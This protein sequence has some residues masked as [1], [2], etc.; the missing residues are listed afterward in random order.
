MG[1]LLSWFAGWIILTQPLVGWHGLAW[2]VTSDPQMNHRTA[3]NAATR[4]QGCESWR[5][6]ACHWADG[7]RVRSLSRPAVQ[8]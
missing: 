1:L 2:I 7:P 6:G 8:R 3:A 4:A 5:L